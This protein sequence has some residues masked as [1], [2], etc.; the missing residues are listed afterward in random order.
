MPNEEPK[1][2]EGKFSEVAR[3]SR[4][5]RAEMERKKANQ[6]IDIMPPPTNGGVQDT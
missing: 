6:D 1:K 5:K 2:A 3:K 4:E